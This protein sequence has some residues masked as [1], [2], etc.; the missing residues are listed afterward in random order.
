MGRE[1][2]PSSAD[3]DP[4]EVTEHGRSNG[5]VRELTDSDA[6]VMLGKLAKAVAHLESVVKEANDEW[7]KDRAA[8]RRDRRRSPVTIAGV[9][10]GIQALVE[11]LRHTGVIK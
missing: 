6:Y 11:A 10:V 3:W 4:E 1:R 7:K 9:M 5:R 8:L 2:T